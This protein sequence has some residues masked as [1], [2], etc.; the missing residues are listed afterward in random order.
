MHLQGMFSVLSLEPALI[1]RQLG[2]APVSDAVLV[3]QRHL[4]CTT[5][6]TSVS[7]LASASTCEK[8]D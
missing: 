3:R 1:R 4:F 6:A 5:Q 7:M 2:G 8:Q